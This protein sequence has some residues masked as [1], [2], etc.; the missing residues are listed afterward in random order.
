M[1]IFPK[2][3]AN[4]DLMPSPVDDRPAV[5]IRDSFRNSNAT[6]IVLPL[7]IFTLQF[8]AGIRSDL[9]M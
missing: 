2:L 7:L 1:V 4:L 6:L 9:E 8:F 3:R 5:L